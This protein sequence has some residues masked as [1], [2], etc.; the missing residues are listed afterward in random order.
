M[1]GALLAEEAFVEQAITDAAVGEGIAIAVLLVVLV[2]VLGGLRAG[3]VPLLSALAAIAVALLVLSGLL[4]VVP[5]N[6]F[7][8]NVVTL[9][10]LGLTVDYSLLVLA[11][12]REERAASPGLPL[13][14]L[15]GRTLARKKE[16]RDWPAMDSGSFIE[17]TLHRLHGSPYITDCRDMFVHDATYDPATQK[18]VLDVTPGERGSISVAGR[19]VELSGKGRR[20]GEVKIP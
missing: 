13:D 6:E 11:R 12:F 5:V 4:G 20:R 14:E 2:V 1:G 7:A 16:W 8:V 10:G 17:W 3:L 15:V 18:V 9:L 19:A